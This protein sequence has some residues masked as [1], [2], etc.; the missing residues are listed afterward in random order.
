MGGELVQYAGALGVG[1]LEP[2]G[3]SETTGT[4]L[5]VVQCATAGTP[6]TD[7]II[8]GPGPT[9]DLAYRMTFSQVSANW[10]DWQAARSQPPVTI[11]ELV[12]AAEAIPAGAN[13]LTFVPPEQADAPPRFDGQLPAD[14][15]RTAACETRAILER[16]AQ[17]LQYLLRTLSPDTPRGPIR[18]AGG[19][20]RSDLLLRI[21]ARTLGLPLMAMACPEPT[22]QGAALAAAVTLGW[23]TRRELAAAWIQPRAVFTP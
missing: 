11:P 14:P 6:V 8:Q 12:A 5:A 10:L 17:E 2:G 18:A 16:V 21:K 19:G 20:A 13:G 22:S 7:G 1:N 9:A 3:I 23:G 4:V 15:A